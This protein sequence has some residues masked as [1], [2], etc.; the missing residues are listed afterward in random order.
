MRRDFLAVPLADVPPYLSVGW[1]FGFLILLSDGVLLIIAKYT[2]QRIAWQCLNTLAKLI[3]LTW[4]EFWLWQPFAIQPCET[5]PFACLDKCDDMQR[6]AACKATNKRSSRHIAA[7]LYA[8]VVTQGSNPSLVLSIQH[9]KN[10]WP[11]TIFL[12]DRPRHFQSKV[13]TCFCLWPWISVEPVV[14]MRGISTVRVSWGAVTGHKNT[15]W[16]T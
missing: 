2:G 13:I 4:I 14:A 8:I 12:F 3:C 10:F 7:W 1:W 11:I 15:S 16:H 5:R 9:L 6:I